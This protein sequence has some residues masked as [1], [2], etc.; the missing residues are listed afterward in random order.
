LQSESFLEPRRNSDNPPAENLLRWVFCFFGAL[1][2]SVLASAPDFPSRGRDFFGKKSLM[3]LPVTVSNPGKERSGSEA[4]ELRFASSPIRDAHYLFCTPLFFFVIPGL[5]RDPACS[6]WIPAFAG[7]TEWEAEGRMEM[8]RR[9]VD[10]R[11]QISGWRMMN[12]LL[13]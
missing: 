5:T 6:F 9:I 7:M 11:L 2:L 3:K 10:C 8:R 4:S 12:S 1:T 13:Q